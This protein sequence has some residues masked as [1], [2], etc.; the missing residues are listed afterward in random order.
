MGE[1]LL[2]LGGPSRYLWSADGALHLMDRSI[3]DLT[4]PLVAHSQQAADLGVVHRGSTVEAIT[5]D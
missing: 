4:N 5:E 2:E 1:G 3:V